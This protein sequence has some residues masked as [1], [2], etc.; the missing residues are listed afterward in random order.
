MAIERPRRRFTVGEY[1]RMIEAGVLAEDDRT[2]LL[3]GE[4]VEMGSIR[5]RQRIGV[6][7]LVASVADQ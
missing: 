1:E 6:H 5:P 2:E 7:G 3:A 4:V